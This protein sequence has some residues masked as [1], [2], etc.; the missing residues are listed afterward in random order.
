MLERQK[1]KLMKSHNGIPNSNKNYDKT[2]Y[3]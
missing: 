1:P 3:F 2:K